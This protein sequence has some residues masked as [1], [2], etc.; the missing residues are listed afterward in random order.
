[1]L[2][3]WKIIYLFVLL[4]SKLKLYQTQWHKP[5]YL[6]KTVRISVFLTGGLEAIWPPNWGDFAKKERITAASRSFKP[7]G[8]AII[9]IV[10]NNNNVGGLKRNS[11]ILNKWGLEYFIHNNCGV[12]KEI[13]PFPIYGG[14]I[15]HLHVWAWILHSLHVGDL[16]R[17]PHGLVNI[18]SRQK[19]YWLGLPPE[20]SSSHHLLFSLYGGS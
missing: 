14:I 10:G 11:L 1:M 15:Y 8:I 4:N 18:V 2:L 7:G 6:P 17:Y 16:E 13:P 9:W 20:D 3:L 19:L 5:P 12:S